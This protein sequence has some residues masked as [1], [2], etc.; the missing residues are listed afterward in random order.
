MKY[1]EYIEN[2]LGSLRAV[3]QEY[4]VAITAER[5]AN[6]ATQDILHRIELGENSYHDLA[7]LAKALREVRQ[8]RRRAKDVQQELQP[9][10]EWIE[11]NFKVIKALERLLGDVRKS[12]KST[13]GRYY[14]Q[15]TDIVAK[16][17]GGDTE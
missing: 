5:E 11:N 15:K 9:I 8:E 16:A 17:L 3:Q 7:K 10:A 12:E 4:S 1:S 2:F 14:N 6:D 13:E